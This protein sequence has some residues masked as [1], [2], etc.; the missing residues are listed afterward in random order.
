MAWANIFLLYVAWNYWTTKVAYDM[1]PKI[2]DL[3]VMEPSVLLSSMVTALENLN[4]KLLRNNI[5]S[6]W[7]KKM[8][9]YILISM[10]F[11]FSAIIEK[12]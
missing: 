6:L 2:A 11:T 10:F 4:H 12:E 5:I 1:H 8:N 9:R 3:K 7:D